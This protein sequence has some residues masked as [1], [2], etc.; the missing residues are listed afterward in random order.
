MATVNFPTAKP[1]LT[2]LGYLLR[3]EFIVNLI[4]P[5]QGGGCVF[6]FVGLSVS[7]DGSKNC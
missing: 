6:A 2:L 1:F 4:L 7:G 3:A 5:R